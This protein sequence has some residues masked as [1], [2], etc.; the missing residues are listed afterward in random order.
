MKQLR[1]H[2]KDSGMFPLLEVGGHVLLPKCPGHMACV[3]A[4]LNV[5]LITR[6]LFR[7]NRCWPGPAHQILCQNT[8]QNSSVWGRSLLLFSKTE[9]TVIHPRRVLSVY[10][11]IPLL[12]IIWGKKSASFHS[13]PKF[14]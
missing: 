7:E 2:L 5:C 9:E 13:K 14:L 11:F 8:A 3:Q 6:I 4:L 1:P 10:S 12:L